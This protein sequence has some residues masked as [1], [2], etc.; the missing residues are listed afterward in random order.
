MKNLI[1]TSLFSLVLL[2]TFGPL[3]SAG[4]IV[5]RERV[6]HPEGQFTR[7]DFEF[8]NPSPFGDTLFEVFAILIPDSSASARGVFSYGMTWAT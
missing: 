4:P 1:T 5:L 7:F 2:A 8:E 6:T 3:S